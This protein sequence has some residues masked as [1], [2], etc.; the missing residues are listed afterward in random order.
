MAGLYLHIP[1]C[2]KACHYCDFHF[3][4]SGRLRKEILTSIVKEME[5]HAHAANLYSFKT[6]YF[7]GG[8]PSLLTPEELIF[9]FE[10]IYYHF[11]I[12]PEA[13]ITLEAN[14]SDLNSAYLRELKQTPINRLSIGLQS[15]DEA[16]LRWMNRDHSEYES[17]QAVKLAFEAGFESLNVDLIYG[18][19]GTDMAYWERQLARMNELPVH[20]LSAYCLTVEPGTALAHFV[21]KGNSKPV[22]E[23]M[24][25][26]HFGMLKTWAAQRGW[27]HYEMSN[28]C[29]PGH[30]ARHN[31]AY[32]NLQPYLGLGPSAHSYTGKERHANV[33]SN[34]KYVKCLSD[35]LQSWETEHLSET[36]HYHDWLLTGFR[37]KEGIQLVNMPELPNIV[38]THFDQEIR[39]LLEADKIIKT[40]A[41]YVIPSHQWFT[42]DQV[43]EA[44]FYVE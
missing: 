27:E 7:G 31:S 15:F 43:L 13:E 21:K 18:I 32:W 9:L 5:V 39:K 40:P 10:A 22:D 12:A 30:Q 1:F 6:I 25:A 2:R 34:P 35:S 36:D 28:F 23:E 29:Q 14:P 44:L 37:T 8:T 24:A 20:H 17:V 33:A 3:S 4:T 19:P 38:K 42:M 16:Q 26:T 41:G 11:Q